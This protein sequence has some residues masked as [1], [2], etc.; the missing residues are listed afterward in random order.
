MRNPRRHD[1]KHLQF[2][3][4]L[5]CIRCLDNTATEAAHL[6][7]ADARIA[8][9]ITGISIKPDDRFVLP[10]CGKDHRRQHAIGEKNFWVDCEPEL[11]ALALYSIS[12]D[13]AEG[14]K[15]VQAAFRAADLYTSWK[16]E[17]PMPSL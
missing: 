4:G 16:T 14:E 17:P 5:P 9:P 11:W 6:R 7:R 2:I 3:R 1:E 15:I 13:H 8:K 10:L 12:G